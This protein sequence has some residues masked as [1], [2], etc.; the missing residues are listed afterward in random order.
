MVGGCRP[1]EFQAAALMLS[2]AGLGPEPSGDSLWTRDTPSVSSPLQRRVCSWD[3]SLFWGRADAQLLESFPAQGVSR[4]DVFRSNTEVTFSREIRKRTP[5]VGNPDV[6]GCVQCW[7]SEPEGVLGEGH[8]PVPTGSKRKSWQCQHVTKKLRS[9]NLGQTHL[10][11]FFHQNYKISRA[12]GRQQML[13]YLDFGTAAHE[14]TKKRFKQPEIKMQSYGPK[15]P[16]TKGEDKRQHPL[17]EEESRSQQRAWG[18]L[19]P[20]QDLCEGSGRGNRAD[21][22]EALCRGP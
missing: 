15:G 22:V 10:L 4:G 18:K 5:E 6:G 21:G 3:T 14:I 9:L 19:S 20:S 1:R 2:G 16:E 17:R 8:N 11:A 13:M 12:Q 7:R